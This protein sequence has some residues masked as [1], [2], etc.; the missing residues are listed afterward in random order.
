M[1]DTADTTGLLT[2]AR[3]NG[4]TGA[5]T[6]YLL[7]VSLLVAACQYRAECDIRIWEWK[8]MYERSHYANSRRVVVPEIL[9]I[10][11]NGSSFDILQHLLSIMK[12]DISYSNLVQRTNR[13]KSE[14]D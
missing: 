12:S 6:R 13:G 11:E 7:S 1:E 4:D 8:L 9:A 14:Y 3:W 2:N 10:R 5:A